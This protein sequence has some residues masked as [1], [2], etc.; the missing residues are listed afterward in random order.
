MGRRPA[1][2]LAGSHALVALTTLADVFDGLDRAATVAAGGPGIWAPH[3][4][5]R[6]L[7]RPEHDHAAEA[8]SWAC[9]LGDRPA[10][11]PKRCL[12]GHMS[13]GNGVS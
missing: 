2:V 4:S 8:C 1:T 9:P 11:T 6:R 3:G 5:Q 10:D 13:C 7:A 12:V